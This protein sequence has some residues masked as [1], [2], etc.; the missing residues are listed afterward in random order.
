[1]SDIV[2]AMAT[3]AAILVPVVIVAILA[4]IAAVK[5]GEAQH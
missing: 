4:S 2:F 1:M 5:K 3:G